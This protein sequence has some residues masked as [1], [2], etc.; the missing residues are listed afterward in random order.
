M[1]TE[2]PK[3]YLMIGDK[4]VLEHTLQALQ[5]HQD[6]HAIM[7]VLSEDDSMVKKMSSLGFYTA[8]G[9]NE[10]FQSVYN[11]LL[12]LD[13]MA[14]E[15][16]WVLVHDAARPCLRYEDLARLIETVRQT[17]LGGLLASPVNDTIKAG[18][19]NQFVT[20]TVD[21]SQLWRALTPQMFRLGQLR[22][23][24]NLVI[25]SGEV[26]TDEAEAME[27]A[28]YRVQLVHGSADNIKITRPEDVAFVQMI[29]QQQQRLA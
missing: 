23:A 20:S 25:D 4:T 29:L 7:V 14:G 27:R 22:K 9:G 11:G 6:I 8:V 3:Q 2:I 15:N 10:R 12:A 13:T 1:G 21:R 19:Q 16:D 17:E 26:V 28:G 18:A 5:G 24:L